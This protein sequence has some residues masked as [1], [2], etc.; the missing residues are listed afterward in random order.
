MGSVVGIG[1]FKLSFLWPIGGVRCGEAQGDGTPGGAKESEGLKLD[2]Y[3]SKAIL[4][5]IS[6]TSKPEALDIPSTLNPKLY[7]RDSVTFSPHP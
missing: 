1:K 2:F 4:Q 5:R 6:V 3:T 7:I